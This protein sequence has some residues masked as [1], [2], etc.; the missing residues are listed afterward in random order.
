MIPL[1]RTTRGLTG[2][3]PV[4]GTL[5]GHARVCRFGA[6]NLG[7]GQLTTR[8]VEQPRASATSTQS[9]SGQRSLPEGLARHWREIARA[10]PVAHYARVVRV[11]DNA[12]WQR[13][14]LITQALKERSHLECSRVPRYR[15]QRQI[16]ERCWRVLRRRATHHRLLLTLA[17]LTHAL[18]HSRCDDQTLQHRVRSLSQSPKTGHSYPRLE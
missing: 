14:A 2:H 15:P 12:P 9:R 3:R 10:Y 13:G 6:L 4:V 17:Q 8:L 18:R 7:T 16:I 1:R 5:D 11:I